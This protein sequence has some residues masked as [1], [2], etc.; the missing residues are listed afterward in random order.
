M[1]DEVLQGRKMVRSDL[2]HMTQE[3]PLVLEA[4]HQ[5]RVGY[6]GL[7]A[8]DLGEVAQLL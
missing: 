5:G 7:G 8:G 3:G 1:M 6:L 2:K 4:M